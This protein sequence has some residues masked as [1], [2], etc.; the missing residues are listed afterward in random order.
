MDQTSTPESDLT[1]RG[2][3]VVESIEP[4]GILA[5]PRPRLGKHLISQAHP[6]HGGGQAT[7]CL[8]VD[9]GSHRKHD[10]AQTPER[11]Y[12]ID[13]HGVVISKDEADECIGLSTSSVRV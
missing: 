10:G 1:Y 13:A 11:P 7:C 3:T 4:G 6:G 2:I 12:Q 8:P 9:D 5:D